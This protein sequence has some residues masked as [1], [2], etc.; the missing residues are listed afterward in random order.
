MDKKGIAVV[1]ILLVVALFSF[2]FLSPVVDHHSSVQQ[3][4]PTQGT[5][6]STG[7]DERSTDE[8][9]D[10]RPVI[11][12][13]YTVDGE[14]YT[15][16]NVYPGQFTR[17]Y[18]S[19]ST[20]AATTNRYAE[21]S[22]QTADGEPVMVYYNPE[23]PEEAYLHNT[24][25]PGQ[26]YAPAIGATI[27]FL[28]GAYLVWVGFRRWRQ[29]TLMQDTPT[30]N[31]QSLSVGPSELSGTAVPADEPMSAPFSDDDCVVAEYEVEEYDT[32]GDNNT[33]DTVDSDVLF[34]PFYV[35][36]STGKVLVRPHEE[37]TY[38]LE[39]EDESVVFVESNQQGPE[40]VQQFVR[41]TDGVEF[42]SD[43]NLEINVFGHDLTDDST[44]DSDWEDEP[45]QTG[46]TSDSDWKVGPTPTRGERSTSDSG[47][48][49]GETQTE[50]D[51]STSDGGW[52]DEE[53]QT[54][55]GSTSDSG[56]R[57]EETQ[58][59]TD[60]S[61]SDGGWKD[62]ETQTEADGSTS[63][64]G[65]K[66]GET[67]TGEGSTS[68]SGW[69]DGETQTEADGSTS[70]SGWKDGETQTEADSTSD[71]DWEGGQTQTGG[72][73]SASDGDRKYRQKLIQTGEDVYVFG[74]ARPRDRE[75]VPE[76]AS[77]ADRLVVE[78]ITDGSMQEPMF[79]LSDDEEHDLVDRRRW[80]LWRL[81]AGAVFL[82]IGFAMLLLIL[83]PTL[84]LEVPRAFDGLVDGVS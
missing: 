7:I 15:A 78:K 49:D 74:T 59:E 35:E 34:R 20:A 3:N 23:N 9:R 13:Q 69:K 50:A 31:A 80:A 45:T 12:Y 5:V 19:R 66:D 48:G 67:Q 28:G 56:W 72:D 43:S 77:N 36:D 6:L 62:E 33:W 37:A 75:N 53:T 63:D 32:S 1:V 65:W 82:T 79:L 18:G 24:G 57:D 46:A 64:S 47:W 10:Y 51:G 44:S 27:V 61:T 25:W 39:P 2:V 21:G 58:T 42:P 8:G 68:D 11:T 76:D 22:D 83:A 29:R 60:G 16:E 14:Q 26:W 4:E 71:S 73:I 52:K 40:A 38:N 84:G 30:E 81:P 70:D 54:G 55:E 41:N 17:W